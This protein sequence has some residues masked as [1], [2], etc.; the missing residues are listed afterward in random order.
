[1]RWA[2]SAGKRQRWTCRQAYREARVL[3]MPSISGR[4]FG[5][6]VIRSPAPAAC[7]A[8]QPPGAGAGAGWAG[9]LTLEPTRRLPTGRRALRHPL[10]PNQTQPAPPAASRPSPP[11][12]RH[13]L[14]VG[15]LLVSW[16]IHALL[17]RTD[18]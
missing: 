13:P 12:G 6:T 4:I 16:L 10:R 15:Q 18:A 11:C 1:M 5:R 14:M 8:G 17:H 2:M 7:R 9:G 3:L